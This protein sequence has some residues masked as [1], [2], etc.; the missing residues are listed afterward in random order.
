MKSELIEVV[1]KLLKKAPVW[2]RHDLASEDKAA[3]TR[4]EEA[5]AAMIAAALEGDKNDPRS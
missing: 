5:L 1:T 4:A 2:L 3:R